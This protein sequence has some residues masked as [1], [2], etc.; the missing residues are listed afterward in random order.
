M[1]RV[2]TRRLILD[3]ALECFLAKGFAATSIADIKAR[4]KTTTGSIYHFFESKDDIAQTLC[5]E[6]LR[7]KAA[8]GC[9]EM[10]GA[11]SEAIVRAM[12]AGTICWAVENEALH[13]YLMQSAFIAPSLA[14][15]SDLIDVLLEARL[16][17]ERVLRVL[18]SSGAVRSVSADLLGVLIL[19]PAEAYL[20]N[21]AHGRT[22]STPEEAIDALG[23]AAWRAVRVETV[24][25]VETPPAASSRPVVSP[26][27][28]D[29][30]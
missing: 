11:S 18:I 5:A 7:S 24:E 8:A 1:A 10:P 4:S 22:T 2:D 16:T 21:R 30:V 15:R 20:V 9:G 12:V 26:K 6:G 13:R 28:W 3:A 14:L 29:L 25:S 23:E 27:H 19:G 17:T